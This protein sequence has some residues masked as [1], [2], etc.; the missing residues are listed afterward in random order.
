[1]KLRLETASAWQ[2]A[3]EVE[4][5]GNVLQHA[6]DHAKSR[7]AKCEVEKGTRPTK[8]GRQA[9]REAPVEVARLVPCES[10]L[11]RDASRAQEQP[12]GKPRQH[13]MQWLEK[14]EAF[15][16]FGRHLRVYPVRPH[17]HR[18]CGQEPQHELL[19]YSLRRPRAA[20]PPP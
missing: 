20:A 15:A 3:D 19:A 7:S 13:G 8:R 9:A 4:V 2:L 1:M 16:D 17:A 18:R 5:A 12:R 14:G 6:A 10:G 11:R